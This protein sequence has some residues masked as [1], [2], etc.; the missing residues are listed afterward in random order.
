VLD[1]SPSESDIALAERLLVSYRAAVK[2]LPY[3][4]PREGNSV[5][6]SIARNVF[7]DYLEMLSHGRP[8]TL[9]AYLCN[10]YR[11]SA[12]HGTCQGQWEYGQ[13]AKNDE[14][15]QARLLEYKDK[16]VCLAE[17]LGVRMVENP[18]QGMW[19]EAIQQNIDE[20]LYSLEIELGF[21]ISPPAIDGGLYKLRTNRGF[22]HERDLYALH[23]AIFVKHRVGPNA[24]ICE[25]GGG[26][27]K[28]ANWIR[29]IQDLKG[30]LPR[31]RTR[32]T[33]LDLP[34]INVLQGF[35]LERSG[36]SCVFFG[37]SPSTN[38]HVLLCPN[39]ARRE[40]LKDATFDLVLNQDSLPEIPAAEVYDY[41]QWIAEHA[42]Y[43]YS[44]NQESCPCLPDGTRQV[45]V[46]RLARQVPKLSL[47]S[48]HPY[49][50][51]RGYVEEFY[52]VGS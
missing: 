28:A 17:A 23:A 46:P 38:A 13:F 5:W 2:E 19:G 15:R 42:R 52:E 27:G 44:V 1:L 8:D 22:F 40:A 11:G 3:R 41:L 9:A 24:N 33:I 39:L 47:V 51:R 45:S 50:L 49:W 37:E 48:R 21:S 30:V 29:R 34:H 43:F 35:N 36:T 6:S 10:M 26:V 32:I 7:S 12:T 4:D 25:I 20:L 31:L 16:I 18:E 14:F